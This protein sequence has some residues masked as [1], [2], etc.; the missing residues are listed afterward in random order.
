LYSE[1]KD[2]RGKRVGAAFIDYIIYIVFTFIIALISMVP[3]FSE[4][5]SNYFLAILNYLVQVLIAFSYFTLIPYLLKGRTIGKFV[6]GIKIIS[7]NYEK[8]SIWKL[9]F[10]NY[11]FF[12]TTFL[13]GLLMLISVDITFFFSVFSGNIMNL[14]NFI[15]LIIVLVSK[16]TR[17][18]HDYIAGTIVVSKHFSVESVN[19]VNAL[20]R[21]S[22]DWAIFE[23]EEEK[24]RAEKLDQ[25]TILKDHD[26]ID[27]L[28][29]KD[30][31]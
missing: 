8:A 21:K 28:K 14:I 1:P 27:L 6:T 7:Y 25:I 22:M 18:F 9:L 23:E 19:E 31:K 2:V 15:N 26:E 24:G 12:I 5:E 10:R 30:I 17:G 20:E 11:Y 29:N 3:R 4:L 13:Q 16:E